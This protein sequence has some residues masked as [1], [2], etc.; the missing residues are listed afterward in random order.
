[1]MLKPVGVTAAATSLANEKKYVRF[2]PGILELVC[3]VDVDDPGQAG[4]PV[5]LENQ[6]RGISLI[7]H[8]HHR[9]GCS[10]AVQMHSY[11][12]TKGMNL[13]F[14]QTLSF[15]PFDLLSKSSDGWT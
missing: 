7:W 3:L 8:Q 6:P 2:L 12:D 11:L 10:Y 14:E 5:S 1:M 4:C 15:S 9:D 13:V